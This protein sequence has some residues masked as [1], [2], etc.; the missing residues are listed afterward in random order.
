MIKYLYDIIHI[1]VFCL[2]KVI[3]IQAIV[4]FDFRKI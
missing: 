2:L 4:L 1:H 3:Y